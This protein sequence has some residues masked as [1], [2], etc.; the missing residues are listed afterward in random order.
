MAVSYILTSGYLP[1]PEP[2]LIAICLL[3]GLAVGAT[4]AFFIT[5]LRA[6]SVIVTLAMVLILGG[7]VT[8]FSQFRAPGDAPEFLRYIGQTRIGDAAGDGPGLARR[9]DSD[10]D[11]PARSRCSARYVDAIGANPRAAW[12]SGIPYV[13]G[14]LRRAH[15]VEPVRGPERLSCSSASS[16]SAA[17][18]SVPIWR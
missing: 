4:N 17:S 1:F 9:A 6:S 15:P 13:Q 7:V 11:L 18:A 2:V 16:A 14:D 5:R 3:L 12:A 10:G 8:A